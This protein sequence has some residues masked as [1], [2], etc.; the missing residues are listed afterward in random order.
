M[1]RFALIVFVAL[2]PTLVHADTADFQ[3]KLRE[4]YQGK[5]FLLRGFYRGESLLYGSIGELITNA[6]SGD[7]TSDGFVTIDSVDAS[8]D[9]IVMNATRQLV[10]V[11]EQEFHFLPALRKDS[12]E[13][14][15]KPEVVVIELNIGTNNPS[16]EQIDS[17]LSKIF[18]T[19]H[20]QLPDVVPEYWRNCLLQGL[21]RKIQFC[22]F[23]PEIISAPG[24]AL[25]E[26]N[27]SSA[28]SS[29]T[30]Y[31]TPHGDDLYLKGSPDQKTFR[32]GSGVKPPQILG[33]PEPEFSDAARHVKYQGT[34]TI[35]MI[36]DKDGVPRNLQILSPLGSG[37]DAK[38][39]AAV[40]TWRFKPATK[41]G[42]PVAVQIA[43]E[44][45]FHLY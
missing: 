9:R 8:G 24:I 26:E 1:R 6:S 44:V 2:L 28:S 43:V 33:Q 10:I 31:S 40:G 7:W 27:V 20:D 3:Q 4:Q 34:M 37:L 45:D 12:N 32:I 16:S 39:I 14:H 17:A 22:R 38:A 35:G 19:S 11:K 42:E 13:K 41:D 29:F 23:S 18:L 25:A 5:T 15:K 30:S 36:V 21:L